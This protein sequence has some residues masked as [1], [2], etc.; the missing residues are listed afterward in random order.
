RDKPGTGFGY[1]IGVRVQSPLGP[2]RLDFGIN[3]EG[4]NRVHF[5]IGERY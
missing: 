1:G 2:I 4:D 3:D 5:G